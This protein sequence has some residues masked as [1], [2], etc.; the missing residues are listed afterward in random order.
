MLWTASQVVRKFS[1]TSVS[2]RRLLKLQMMCWRLW[3][4]RGVGESRSLFFN[5]RRWVARSGWHL[6]KRRRAVPL[7]H[8]PHTDRALLLSILYKISGELH[9]PAAYARAAHR[10]C[11][12]VCSPARSTSRGGAAVRT[13]DTLRKQPSRVAAGLDSAVHSFRAHPLA[14]EGEEERRS[15][16]PS[17]RVHS[18]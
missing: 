5:G 12:L 10:R 17:G 14:V 15:T 9:Q 8:V 7:C 3:L 18:S 11:R 6:S 1:T 16:V 13:S 2:N 4:A